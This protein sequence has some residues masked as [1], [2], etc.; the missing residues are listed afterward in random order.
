LGEEHISYYYYYFHRFPKVVNQITV[1]SSLSAEVFSTLAEEFPSETSLF[2]YA[3]GILLMKVDL[4]D[5]LKVGYNLK[6]AQAGELAT[7]ILKAMAVG[8]T[9][10]L[11]TGKY[12]IT[13]T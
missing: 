3:E 12:F 10:A 2:N 8:S 11:S 1:G 4:I 7:Y 9:P 13:M 5:R 6:E